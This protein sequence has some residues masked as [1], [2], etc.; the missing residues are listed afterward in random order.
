M[1]AY[2][3][4]IAPWGEEIRVRECKNEGCNTVAY[5]DNIA[6]RFKELN[7]GQVHSCKFYNKRPGS[8]QQQG[9]NNQSQYNNSYSPQSSNSS[10]GAVHQGQTATTAIEVLLKGQLEKLRR[11]VDHLSRI[12]MFAE[13]L[14][15]RV[16]KIEERITCS[17]VPERPILS[18]S[19]ESDEEIIGGVQEVQ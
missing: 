7:T 4:K 1:S 5:F 8:P 19:T 11:T 16:K 9:N 14:D 6:N 3:T 18:E 15:F 17:K 10:N 13:N 12:A 2:L